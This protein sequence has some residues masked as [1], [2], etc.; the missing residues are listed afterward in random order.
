MDCGTLEHMNIIVISIIVTIFIIIILINSMCVL[1]YFGILRFATDFIL[2]CIIPI[3]LIQ[4]HDSFS[5]PFAS[6]RYRPQLV[7]EFGTFL[8][9]TVGS[10]GF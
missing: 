5:L 2:G 3:T 10:D 9:Q 8:G 1:K 4:R 6:F 7:V